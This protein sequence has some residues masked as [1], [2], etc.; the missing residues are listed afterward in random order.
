MKNIPTLQTTSLMMSIMLIAPL[1]TQA[2]PM[3]LT[4]RAPRGGI[5][6]SAAQ[7]TAPKDQSALAKVPRMHTPAGLGTFAEVRSL[8]PPGRNRASRS[9]S[10]GSP[11]V[12]FDGLPQIVRALPAQVV[13]ALPNEFVPPLSGQM[14]APLPGQLVL[15]LPG[16][17][18]GPLPGQITPPLPGQILR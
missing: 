4:A 7:R 6:G 3:T 16:Q 8:Q 17:L 11:E 18:V 13:P 15:S 2:E 12:S 14:T 10:P 1:F 5:P 9:T